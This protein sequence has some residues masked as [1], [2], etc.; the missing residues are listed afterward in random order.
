MVSPAHFVQCHTEFQTATTSIVGFPH[1]SA[2]R[3]GWIPIRHGCS[4]PR[5]QILQQLHGQHTLLGG[6][7]HRL[8]RTEIAPPD[9]PSESL[10]LNVDHGDRDHMKL[11][12][13]T[14]HE[15]CAISEG[16]NLTQCTLRMHY[17][18]SAEQYEIYQLKY[19]DSP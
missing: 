17:D 18:L 15:P 4:S 6:K 10:L 8:A 9:P 7:K 19:M 1:L 11:L 3:P 13:H 14:N 16:V 5:P 12:R 2:L